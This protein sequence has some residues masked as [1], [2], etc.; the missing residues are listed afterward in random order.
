MDQVYGLAVVTIIAAGGTNAN[1]G[2]AGVRPGTRQIT[3][4]RDRVS[5]DLE[6]AVSLPITDDIADSHWWFRAWTFQEQLLSKRFLIFRDRQVFWQYRSGVLCEDTLAENKPRPFQ[7]LSSTH[8]WWNVVPSTH[9][10][11]AYRN[12]LSSPSTSG[13]CRICFYCE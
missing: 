1:D 11:F 3:Q 8:P 10:P 5:S 9:A 13:V 6:V 7:K 12:A 2:L 4:I